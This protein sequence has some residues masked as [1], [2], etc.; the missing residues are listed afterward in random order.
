MTDKEEIRLLQQMVAIQD[1]MISEMQKQLI[2][3]EKVISWTERAISSL[4]I[5]HDKEGVKG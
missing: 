4:D 3:Y 1:R 2:A 5:N